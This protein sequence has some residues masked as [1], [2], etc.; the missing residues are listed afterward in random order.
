MGETST[1]V[2]LGPFRNLTERGGGRHRAQRGERGDGRHTTKKSQSLKR[3]E[4]AIG[5]GG[6]IDPA[7]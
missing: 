7:A 5:K 6:E 1:G 4:N 3:L 2:G